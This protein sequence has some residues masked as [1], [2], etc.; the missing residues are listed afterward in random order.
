VIQ[1]SSNSGSTWT[2]FADGTSTATSTAVTGLTN[3][4]AYIFKVAAVNAVG[5]GSYSS[6]SSS[7]TPAGAP[8][9]APTLTGYN[10]TVTSNGQT[11]Y[12]YDFCSSSVNVSFSA[13]ANGG[14]A[15]TNYQ[16]SQASW[17]GS[18]YVP[19]TWN[20]FSP[21]KTTSPISF[22][23]LN[24]TMEYFYFIRAKNAVGTGPTSG[25]IYLAGCN[26]Y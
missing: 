2:T 5:T 26:V 13:G 23:G 9:G 4:T 25:L 17:N 12:E 15:I 20:D 19:T 21:A 22:T 6:N 18:N 7:V 3:G 10:T 11:Y 14:S 24:N 8:T 16:L 1:Y